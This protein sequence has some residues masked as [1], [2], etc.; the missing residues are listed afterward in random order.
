[1]LNI[2][3]AIIVCCVVIFI[4]TSECKNLFIVWM[5]K[6]FYLTAFVALC[7]ILAQFNK[8]NAQIYKR[9]GSELIVVKSSQQDSLTGITLRTNKDSVYAIYITP[10]GRCYIK[11]HSK[12]TGKEYKHY[13]KEEICV[14]I[15]NELG[16]QY[17]KK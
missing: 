9:V 1:M 7:M 12:R 10:K 17:I 15:C 13:L 11:Q 14:K 6:M 5:A 16:K 4:C 8:A 2:A 3:I